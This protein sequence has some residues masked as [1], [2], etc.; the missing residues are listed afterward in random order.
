MSNSC[1]EY[2]SEEY[3]E[4]TNDNCNENYNDKHVH[5]FT[6]SVKLAETGDD[7]HNHRTAGITSEPIYCENGR[8]YHLIK[9]QTD[10]APDDHHHPIIIRTGL[11]IKIRGTNKHVHAIKGATRVVD[12]HCHNFEFA[13]LTERPLK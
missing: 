1:N 10:S 6:G 11:D 13:T 8:H 3:N 7:R 5:E 9:A 12:Q 4:N 2:Y